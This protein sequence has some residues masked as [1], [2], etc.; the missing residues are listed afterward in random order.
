VVELG[1]IGGAVALAEEGQ[2]GGRG[3]AVVG[4]RVADAG[5]ELIVGGQHPG[6]AEGLDALVVAEAAAAAVGDVGEGAVGGPEDDHG[7]VD[8]TGLLDE[9]LDQVGPHGLHLDHVAEQ[10]AGHVEV[11]DGH[12]AE[13]AAGGRDVLPGRGRRVAAGDRDQL[14]AADVA[15]PDAVPDLPERAV[16]AA[17]E[18]DHHHRRQRGD[19][20]GGRLHRVADPGQLGPRVLGHR[21]RVDRADPAAAEQRYS[22]HSTPLPPS[23]LTVRNR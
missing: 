21:L 15:G 16:E 17:V 5:G 13:Q 18:A 10:E 23:C 1:G 19:L 14:Q 12:I 7:A 8:V 4:G 22:H 6:A 20:G 9:R 3:L 2:V 11:V